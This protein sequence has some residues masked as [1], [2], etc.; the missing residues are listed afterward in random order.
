MPSW[1]NALLAIL[2]AILLVLAYP[3]FELWF[4][5]WF[6]LVPLLIAV[7]FEKESSTRSFVLGWMFGFIFF[8]GTCWW[9][10]YA[11]IHYAGFPWPLAYFLLFCVTT[12]VGVFPGLFT[13]VSAW[14]VLT[15]RSNSLAEIP[16]IWVFVEFLRYWLTGN[17]WNA[18]GYSMAFN[19]FCKFFA[20]YGGIYLVG[21]VLVSL[22]VLMMW[23]IKALVINR[24]P[25][26]YYL[27]VFGTL[28]AVRDVFIFIV[29]TIRSIQI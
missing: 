20:A 10:T 23:A 15:S 18:I 7:E 8:S 29:A 1:K 17:N 25:K 14:R 12:V 19:D 27:V 22:N 6:A 28:A 26:K 24:T 16:F 13:L 11:P 3:D 4:L 5:A 21:Y 9:L 2:S